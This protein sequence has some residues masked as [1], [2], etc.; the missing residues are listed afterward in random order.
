MGEQRATL[1]GA[2]ALVCVAGIVS[3]CQFDGLNS[4]SLPGTAGHGPGSFEVTLDLSNVVGLPQN[5][6][7]KVGDVTVGSVSGVAVMQ[8]PD[9]TVYAAVRVSLDRH[10]V[11]PANATAAVGQTSLLG[12]QHVELAAPTDQPAR[13]QL[14]DGAHIQQGRTGHYPTTE[15]V[16]AALGVIVNNGNLG[17][18]HDITDEMYAAVAGRG[19]TFTGLVAR[20]AE[21]TS[22]LDAQTNTIIAAIEGVDRTAEVL[23]QNADALR[24]T[25]QTLPAALDVLNRNRSN[26]VAAFDALRRFASTAERVLSQTKDDFAADLK[27]MFP[28]ILA[29][30]DNADDFI[31]DLEILPTFPFDRKYLRNAVRGDYLNVFSTFDLTMRRLGENVF[32]TSALDPNMAHL[33]EIIN[34]PD[35]LVGAVANLSGQ[36]ADPFTIPP[37][38]A[39]QHDAKP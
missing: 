3:G 8:R 30:N 10:V 20:M 39:T 19:A 31:H 33:A 2:A 18:L 12:S 5:S 11:L 1:R 17:A 28:A 23:A 4:L 21:L 37:G 34:P 16:L 36:A 14:T 27:D 32:P 6:P 15:D 25:L 26:I 7:V 29:F 35:F 24:R 9:S 13:G 22:F 38:T